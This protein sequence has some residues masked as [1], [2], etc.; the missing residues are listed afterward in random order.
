MAPPS[1]RNPAAEG[2]A[3]GASDTDRL[4]HQIDTN[5]NPFDQ[6]LQ[7]LATTS[8][9]PTL[10]ILVAEWPRNA[11]ETIRIALDELQGKPTML[12]S[13]WRAE[14]KAD[15][16]RNAHELAGYVEV[17]PQPCTDFGSS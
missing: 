11:R 7:A 14:S 13:S 16:K 4:Q 17:R 8:T 5:D 10:P 12:F 15:W 3:N 9:A 2:S 1:T 6:A